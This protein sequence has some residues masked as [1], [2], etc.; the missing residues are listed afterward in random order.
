M[1]F[2]PLHADPIPINGIGGSKYQM[3]TVLYPGWGI[4]PRG[5]GFVV[6]EEFRTHTVLTMV[7]S[8]GG[9]WTILNALFSWFFGRSLLFPLFGESLLHLFYVPLTQAR[10]QHVQVTNLYR[11]SV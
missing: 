2:L 7:A 6:T 10:F 1:C 11:H 5:R 9:L 8:I 3:W 4:S